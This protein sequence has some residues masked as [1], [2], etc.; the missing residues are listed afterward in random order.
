MLAACQQQAEA[1]AKAA[2][3]EQS[4]LNV[5]A[6]LD[7][8]DGRHAG[9]VSNLG[10]AARS[11]SWLFLGQSPEG[12]VRTAIRR[13]YLEERFSRGFGRTSSRASARPPP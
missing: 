3:Q 13:R 9:L 7:A 4:H 10:L 8:L 12:R 11:V 5:L 6:R 1:L 2:A